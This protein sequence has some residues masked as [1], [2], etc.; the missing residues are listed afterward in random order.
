MNL[1]KETGPFNPNVHSNVTINTE[2]GPLNFRV[3][4]DFPTVTKDFMDWDFVWSD[5]IWDQWV[6]Q[7]NTGN[8]VQSCKVDLDVMLAKT[9]PELSS[10]LRNVL[11][12]NSFLKQTAS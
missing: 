2:N 8:I 3:Y 7:Q 10:L 4:K 12:A 11:Q 1:Y 6:K 5:Y 9:D